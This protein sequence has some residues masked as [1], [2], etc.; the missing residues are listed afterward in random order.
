MGAEQWWIHLVVLGGV[1]QAQVQLPLVHQCFPHG[2]DLLVYHIQRRVHHVVE[3]ELTLCRSASDVQRVIL[4][5][6]MAAH[7]VSSGSKVK[8]KALVCSQPDNDS[9]LLNAL[10]HAAFSDITEPKEDCLQRVDYKDKTG[11]CGTCLTCTGH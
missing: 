1:E 3:L 8:V 2:R 10:W 5:E 4:Q 7:P 9:L 6:E 11:W